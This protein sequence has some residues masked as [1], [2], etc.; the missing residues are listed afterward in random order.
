[1][2]IYDF[3]VLGVNKLV[4]E[5]IKNYLEELSLK[6]SKRNTLRKNFDVHI[7]KIQ[8]VSMLQMC[9]F[10]CKGLF[11]DDCHYIRIYLQII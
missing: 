9:N 3:K 4:S 6:N 7:A 1:M 8:Y 2:W 5:L 11:F 10:F